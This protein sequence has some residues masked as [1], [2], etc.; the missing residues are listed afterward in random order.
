MTSDEAKLKACMDAMDIRA[1]YAT[2]HQAFMQC[3]YDKWQAAVEYDIPVIWED[4]TR[5]LQGI[6]SYINNN[7][8]MFPNRDLHCDQYGCLLEVAKERLARLS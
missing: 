7:P 5:H 2:N 6:M 3:L 4:I 8:R 1:G